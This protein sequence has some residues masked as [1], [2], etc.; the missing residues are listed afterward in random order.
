[1]NSQTKVGILALVAVVAV[2]LTISWLK[3]SGIFAANQQTYFIFFTNVNGLK[4]SDPVTIHG[5][6]VGNVKSL[7]PER[8][9]VLVEVGIEANTMLYK[10]A[11]A[12]ILIKEILSGKQIDISPGESA[13]KLL[14]GNTIQGKTNFDFSIALQKTALLFDVFTAQRL[15]SLL[16]KFEKLANNLANFSAATTPATISETLIEIRQTLASLKQ[17][18]D[19]LT[20]QKTIHKATTTLDSIRI[21][22]SNINRLSQV[23]HQQIDTTVPKLQTTLSN[24]DTTLKHVQS[25]TQELQHL[26]TQS[27]QNGS[28]VG[29]LLYEPTYRRRLDSIMQTFDVALKSIYKGDVHVAVRLSSAKSRKALPKY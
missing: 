20:Q 28:V 2:Y 11:S 19:H 12:Q 22:S 7:K 6:T 5:Y 18:S 16:Q 17:V 23:V 1:M 8:H 9:G 4:T 26:L 13:E 10:D 21:L 24:T 27:K 14:P 15:D 25:L 3:D 29:A